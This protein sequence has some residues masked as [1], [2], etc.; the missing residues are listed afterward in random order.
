MHID[1]TS[2]NNG[3]N[4]D[5]EKTSD[6]QIKK[7]SVSV[8]P[9]SE[10]PFSPNHLPDSK[11]ATAERKKSTE[12]N[13]TIQP[14][15]EKPFE[16]KNFSE[17]LARAAEKAR[18]ALGSEKNQMYQT[19]LGILSP[20]AEQAV[21]QY[22]ALFQAKSSD[23]GTRS[24]VR[25]AFDE[26]FIT[27]DEEQR[28]QDMQRKIPANTDIHPVASRRLEK[29]NSQELEQAIFRE[30]GFAL[31]AGKSEGN[32]FIGELTAVVNQKAATMAPTDKGM[33]LV[34]RFPGTYGDVGHIAVGSLW[35]NEEGQLRMDVSHQESMAPTATSNHVYTG[36]IF[37]TFD[38]AASYPTKIAP[39]VEGMKLFG[40]PS[41]LVFPVPFPEILA[42][43][44]QVFEEHEVIYGATDDWAPAK[45]AI[46]QRDADKTKPPSQ[47]SGVPQN[48]HTETCFN[49][50]HKTLARMYGMTTSHEPLFPSLFEKIKG[51]AGIPEK[52]FK[53]FKIDGK[54]LTMQQVATH[55]AH[56]VK[57]FKI[58]GPAWIDS[59]PA[60][61]NGKMRLQ[62]RQLKF[63][64]GQVGF[65][66]E[67]L[68][69]AFKFASETPFLK[70]LHLDGKPVIKDKVYTA[71]EALRITYHGKE[72]SKDI[73]YVVG[74]PL[75]GGAK[76]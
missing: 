39:V 24:A 23:P 5:T 26:N 30:P 41:V 49:V 40:L 71:E 72:P 42:P 56:S 36:R 31:F 4:S 17:R 32:R 51:F 47:R 20:E 73:N 55:Q 64:P 22:S 68:V 13:T 18:A 12:K 50:T 65:P 15:K 53:T 76:L 33:A 44:T 63:Q 2:R 67:G 52:E 38:T 34:F 9:R 25:T 61:V 1:S 21:N 19:Q 37:N 16:Q 43:Y 28:W 8:T 69:R 58:V 54:D 46:K 70:D 11:G 62:S 14:A 66:L 3:I 35:R 57:T 59:G 74:V 6:T 48:I 29:V 75:N 7:K 27:P 60:D 10:K 45:N